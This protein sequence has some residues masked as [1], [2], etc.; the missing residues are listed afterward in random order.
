[1]PIAEEIGLLRY[2]SL[3]TLCAHALDLPE[4][5]YL[6]EGVSRLHAHDRLNVDAMKPGDLVFVKTDGLSAFT[7]A[8]P[9]IK[10]PFGLVTGVSS[11]TPAEFAGL[12]EDER[13]LSWSGPNLPLWSEKIL[14]VP[15][16]F[17][18]RERPHGDQTAILASVGGLPWDERP[19]DILLTSM[20][21]TSPERHGIPL[22]GVHRCA[23]RLSYADYLKLLGQSR[24]V[25]CPRGKGVDTLRFWETLAVG[26]VPIV[27]TSLLDPL[28]AECGA[29]IV[30]DWAEI[31]ER[32]RTH[33][34]GPEFRERA[35]TAFES[36]SGIFFT[37]HWGERIREHH[38]RLMAAG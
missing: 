14:Q 13:I 19:I 33:Q 34:G 12:V 4:D 6:R 24:Y 11:T 8:L 25:I 26:A 2:N 1:M 27:R 22:D 31:T 30:E 32:V 15:I 37:S 9:H 5:Y 21:D 35:L 10:V 29:I 7:N 18:E 20:S 23:D 16:G 3:P 28:Y 36:R 17:S 38:G